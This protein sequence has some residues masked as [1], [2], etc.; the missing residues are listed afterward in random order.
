MGGIKGTGKTIFFILY[1]IY[2]YIYINFFLGLRFYVKYLFPKHIFNGIEVQPL[3]LK[4]FFLR[5]LFNWMRAIRSFSSIF[6]DCLIIRLA[7]EHVCEHVLRGF[8][9]YHYFFLKVN[10][11]HSS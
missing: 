8:S 4:L 11:L 5:S 3:K 7:P 9:N 2:I 10:D 6:L 1:Y